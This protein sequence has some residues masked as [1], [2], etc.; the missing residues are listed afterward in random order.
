MSGE[1]AA[2]TAVGLPADDRPPASPPRKGKGGG[3]LGRLRGISPFRAAA[4]LLGII[5]ICLIGYPVYR[6]VSSLVWSNGHFS[7][8]VIS[9]TI[10]LPNLGSTLLDTAIVVGASGGLAVIVGSAFA[11]L[12]ERTDARMGALTDV[13]P[14]IPFLVPTIA[15]T[16]GWQFLLSP[17][18]GYVNWALR[19]VAHAFGDHITQGPLTVY[20][21]YGVIFVYTIDLIP[22]VFLVVSAGLRGA[23]A[24]LEEQSRVCGAGVLR[25]L[26]SVTLPAI[27]QYLLSAVFLV[28]WFGL[29]VF[30]VP[31]VL[32][33]P[34]HINMLSYQ[35]IDLL[36]FT[37]PPQ[38]ATAIGLGIIVLAVLGTVWFVQRRIQA[39]QRFGVLGGKAQKSNRIRLGWARPLARL[40]LL[41]YMFLATVLPLLSLLLV[42][43][44]GFWT[45]QIDWSRF[46][47][48]A[49]TS[50]L[51][52]AFSY[53]E[54]GTALRN[55]LLLAALSATV[56]AAVA[57]LVAWW[58]LH[59]RGPFASLSSLATKIPAAI[60]TIVL[61]VGFVLAFG[62]PPL[63]LGGTVFILFLAYLAVSMPEA[64]LT[65]EAA[66]S[67][68]G[69]ELAEAS[70]IS[71]AGEG[72]TFRSVYLPLMLP[73]LAAGWALVFV[74]VI[75]D[76]EV[77]SILAGTGNPV[78]GFQ[79]LGMFTNA[80]F[81][82]LAALALMLTVI[83]CVVL[84]VVLLVT[85]K[86]TVRSQ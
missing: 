74:R 32:A 62:G 40:V 85:R 63:Y 27:R 26:I 69:Y 38:L 20:S 4:G 29:A 5:F 76:L 24:S 53:P 82:Q 22:F 86:L 15:S 2:G 6:V 55:S 43:L 41:G 48:H 83:S 67:Q 17:G 71:G 54:T 44:N 19:E 42:S 47:F 49:F 79:I 59:A 80:D 52:S 61:A 28:L 35:I 30:S 57:A 84:A 13:I 3:R 64:S 33:A 72:R 50:A 25:T 34:A 46:G 73:G 1:T 9:D 51:N 12:N 31:L 14:I 56:G 70:R 18:A 8:A 75:A 60:S 45:L 81:S 10:H 77:S 39:S 66:A 65:S 7:N 58:T 78:I 11:W 68:V 36:D 37:S 23:D 16:I 21:W